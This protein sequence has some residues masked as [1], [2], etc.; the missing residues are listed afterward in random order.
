MTREEDVQ[1]SKGKGAIGKTHFP[2]PAP[3][4]DPGDPIPKT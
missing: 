4:H 1:F 3:D 2:K